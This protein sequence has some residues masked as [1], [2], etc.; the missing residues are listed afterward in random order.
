MGVFDGKSVWVTGA[1]TG[2]GKAAALMFAED[3]ASVVLIGR[4][5]EMLDQ[6]AGEIESMGGSA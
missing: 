4:R 5:R 2:I 1:G 3:G 6:V